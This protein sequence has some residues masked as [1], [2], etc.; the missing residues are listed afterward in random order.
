MAIIYTFIFLFIIVFADTIWLPGQGRT[1]ALT[2][3]TIIEHWL[4]GSRAQVLYSYFF[5]S[6]QKYL[7]SLLCVL[8]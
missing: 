3:I 5:P 1:E 4:V 8:F 2:E 6:W 7:K